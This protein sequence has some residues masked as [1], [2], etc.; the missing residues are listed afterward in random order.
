MDTQKASYEQYDEKWEAEMSKFPKAEAINFCAVALRTRN[1][2]LEYLRIRLNQL[3]GYEPIK[4]PKI[5]NG[6]LVSFGLAAIVNL[7][8]ENGGTDF[9]LTINRNL[10]AGLLKLLLEMVDNA[11][12]NAVAE[13]DS[14]STGLPDSPSIDELL[15]SKTIGELKLG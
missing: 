5:I 1:K 14:T 10:P 13:L 11:F 7:N 12:R 8:G 2:E 9:T 6:E 15:A 4:N 3:S